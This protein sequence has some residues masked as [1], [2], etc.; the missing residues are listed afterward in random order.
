MIIF[1]YPGIGKTL[2]YEA[3][4]KQYMDLD[5][6]IFNKKLE[7]GWVEV[8]FKIAEAFSELG[9]DVFVS[10]HDDV[11]RYFAEHSKQPLLLIYPSIYI[12]KD[13]INRLYLRYKRSGLE[14]DYKAWN[15]ANEDMY[16]DLLELGDASIRFGIPEIKISYMNYNLNDLIQDYKKKRFSQE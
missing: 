4:K 14:R 16:M 5:S 10:T 6:Y 1:G 9:K 8:Y 3:N 15:R 11:I 12:S 13:Y 7:E 2:A